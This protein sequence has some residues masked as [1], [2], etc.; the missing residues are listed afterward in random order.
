[1]IKIP[2]ET[3]DYIHIPIKDSN[4]FV[5][6]SFRTISIS[7]L[8]ISAVIGKLKINSSGS[9]T[10]QKYLF[11]KSKSWTMSKVESWVKSH[12]GDDE[13]TDTKE[14]KTASPAGILDAKV[15]GLVKFNTHISKVEILK[16]E[17]A[18]GDKP[19]THKKAIVSGEFFDDSVK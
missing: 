17:D 13:M 1:M 14:A 3:K 9:M 10:V 7:K 5:T 12:K 8:G 16:A 6:K 4:K 11:V 2:E 19:A 18:V 15:K